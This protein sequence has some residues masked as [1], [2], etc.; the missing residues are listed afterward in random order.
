MKML[1][2]SVIGF[3]SFLGVSCTNLTPQQSLLVEK[4]QAI[5]IYPVTR[6]T[7]IKTL[8][9]REVQSQ[10]L[11]GGMRGGRATFTEHWTHPCGLSILAYDSEYVGPSSTNG[12]SIDLILNGDPSDFDSIVKPPAPRKSFDTLIIFT[13]SGKLK[14]D[15]QSIKNTSNKSLH[16]TANRLVARNQ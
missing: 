14:Y 8:D 4:A 11:G 16:P 10:T 13:D 1:L 5:E 15:S 2:F 6:K 9:L 7:L 3:V 12:Q